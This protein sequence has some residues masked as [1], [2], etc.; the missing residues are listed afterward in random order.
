M[1][2]WI[3]AMIEREAIPL[4]ARQETVA[5]FCSKWDID[6]STYYRNSRK[7]ENQKKSL[8]IALSLVKKKAPEILEKLAEKAS[9]GDM[10]AT[11]MFLN[12]VLELSKNLD[13]KSGGQSLVINVDK[14]IADKNNV[15]N[16]EPKDNS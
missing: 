13:L 4:A 5:E 10:K 3:E 12:Y 14:D 15:I 9:A 16:T 6:E 8:K 1:E 11:D 7:D 2:N